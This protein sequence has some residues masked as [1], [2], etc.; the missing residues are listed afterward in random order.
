M[1]GRGSPWIPQSY[2]L[3]R[4]LNM[5]CRKIQNLKLPSTSALTSP[6]TVKAIG[7]T[8]PS[9]TSTAK[10]CDSSIRKSCQRHARHACCACWC[11]VQSWC[12]LFAFCLLVQLVQKIS[13]TFPTNE[14]KCYSSSK[15]K[16]FGYTGSGLPPF[17][18]TACSWNATIERKT[19]K[20]N[21]AIR[22][23]WWYT[24]LKKKQKQNNLLIYNIHQYT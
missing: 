13:H 17:I 1:G 15:G 23:S 10:G 16:T 22:W 20:V 3:L 7:A 24:I 11:A 12:V 8:P 2:E 6:F 4:F 9:S 14:M 5:F 21:R 19:V 18:G